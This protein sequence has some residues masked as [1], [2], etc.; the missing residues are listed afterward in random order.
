MT[1]KFVP[2]ENLESLNEIYAHVAEYIR[3]SKIQFKERYYICSIAAANSEDII[4]FINQDPRIKQWDRDY[5][6][7]IDDAIWYIYE[8]RVLKMPIPKIVEQSLED[9]IIAKLFRK[10]KWFMVNHISFLDNDLKIEDI[11]LFMERDPIIKEWNGDFLMQIIEQ[12]E[13]LKKQ[14]LE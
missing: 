3:R 11:I 14:L 9:K 13:R 1:E 7:R 2:I 12:T 8:E 10:T 4:K 6:R 5:L